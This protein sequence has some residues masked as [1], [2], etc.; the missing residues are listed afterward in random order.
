MLLAVVFCQ[1]YAFSQNRFTAAF[2]E[3]DSTIS[4]TSYLCSDS[5]LFEGTDS[6]VSSVY[7]QCE[8][9]A[10]FEKAFSVIEDDTCRITLTQR[11]CMLLYIAG[12][13]ASAVND[14]RSFRAKEFLQNVKSSASML[15]KY[16]RFKEKF[17]ITQ[18][19]GKNR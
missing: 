12:Y 5:T 13:L 8:D 14:S 10:L 17:V 2:L 16:R 7:S 3:A 1:T 15:D 19:W 4:S 6:L 9:S 11:E 18:T